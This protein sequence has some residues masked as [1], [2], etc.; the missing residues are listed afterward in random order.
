MS[1]SAG[2]LQSARLVT[3]GISWCFA[4]IAAS[5]GLNGLIKSNQEKTR[6]KKLGAPAVVDI[7]TSDIFNV[8]VVATTAS[9]LI[10]ILVSKFLVGMY[11][12]A[13]KALVARTLR[14]Q[15][16][17]LTLACLLLF[18]AMVPYMVFFVNRQAS[19]KAFIG[20]VQLPDS[21]VQGVEATSG[22]TRV[23]KKIFYLKLVAILPWFSLLFSLVAAGTLFVA[24][25]RTESTRVPV[26]TTERSS[27]LMTEKE[28]V[29]HHEKASV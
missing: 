1:S 12:P 19:V 28:D 20:G 15:A 3:L 8:G 4:V 16:I 7:D 11:I 22:T 9:L 26:Q 13:T 5:V 10:A 21:I 2:P 24:S 6:L 23:Y 29:L 17:I 25:S 18:G 14:L 27:P